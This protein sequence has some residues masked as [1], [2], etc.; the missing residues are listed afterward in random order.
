MAWALN[1][2]FSAFSTT[3]SLQASYEA[4]RPEHHKTDFSKMSLISSVLKD[5]IFLNALHPIGGGGVGAGY[6]ERV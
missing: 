6:S 2:V 3:I 5:Y 1:S 4:Q